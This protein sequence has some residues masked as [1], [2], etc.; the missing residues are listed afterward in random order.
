MKYRAKYTRIVE[1]D[2][3]G[4]TDEKA[5]DALRYQMLQDIADPGPGS[6]FTVRLVEDRRRPRRR[7]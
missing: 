3:H 1:I 7:R 6:G 4:N 2:A 5:L